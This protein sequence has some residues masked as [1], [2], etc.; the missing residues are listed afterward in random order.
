MQTTLLFSGGLDSTVCLAHLLNAGHRVTPL[1]VN[2]GQKHGTPESQAADA[3]TEHYRL[4]LHIVTI[5]GAMRGSALTG[6]GDVPR[7]HYEAPSMRATVVPGRNLVL[8]AHAL[9][10]AAE[11]KHEAV[12]YAAHA[13]DHA[14][15]P[16][17]REAFAGAVAAVAMVYDYNGRKLLR[18]FINW[19]K[20]DIVRHGA[21]LD[22]PLESAYSCYNGRAKHCGMCGTCVERRE[23]FGL[24]GVEDPTVYECCS[25]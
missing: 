24:A 20:T 25:T 16:D 22:V 2:Y 7:G 23:A 17:C 10:H 3:I 14:I 18:P 6:T 1:F 12:A 4:P 19:T 15:Y 13:G 11:H 5:T 8:L 21:A 9:A